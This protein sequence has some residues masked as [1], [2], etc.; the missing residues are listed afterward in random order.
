MSKKIYI[1]F[2]VGFSL[3]MMSLSSAFMYKTN[4]TEIGVRVS[5]MAS[6]WG[7][8]AVSDKVAA[9]SQMNFWLPLVQEFYVFDTNI[10]TIEMTIDPGT[11]DLRRRDDL[12]FKTIDGNDI[13]LDLLIQYRIIASKAPYILQHVAIDNSELKHKLV[14]LFARSLPR[15]VFGELTTEEFYEQVKR[16]QKAEAVK[17]ILN[18]M[19]EPYGV[20]IENVL[21]Q[22]YRFNPAYQKAIEDKK[23]ADQLVEK[24]RSA[25]KAALEEYKKKLEEA[26][27]EVNQLVA[28][29]DGV[30]AK[31]KIS[32]DAYFDQQKSIARAIEFE[33]EAESKG[34]R[35]K[36]R[37]LLSEGGRTL[38]KLEIA[39]A[40]QDK[41]I[42]ILP[43]DKGMNL[44]SMDLNKIIDVYGVK[45]L[46]PIKTPVTK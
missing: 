20:V 43:S 29:V 41:K 2:V 7:K 40:L 37:A 33:A 6:F 3:N 16:Q 45:S 17:E 38:V 35:A 30:F 22:D 18:K 1:A 5:K 36:N 26:K 12:L 34:I 27:G 25:A 21:P 23:I 39:K 8:P 9:S 19:V 31:A 46:A 14:R 44:R 24:N 11:G 15:D 42:L 4:S 28:A 10:Q 32:A 13:S